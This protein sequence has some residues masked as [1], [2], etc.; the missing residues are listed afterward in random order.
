MIQGETH[1]RHR[2]FAKTLQRKGRLRRAVHPSKFRP[3]RSG[4]NNS[5]QVAPSRLPTYRAIPS[6]SRLSLSPKSTAP[7]RHSIPANSLRLKWEKRRA[8]GH[9]PSTEGGRRHHRPAVHRHRPAPRARRAAVR[10]SFVHPAHRWRFS[11][12]RPSS[13]PPCPSCRAIAR[14]LAPE[15]RQGQPGDARASV[16]T[17]GAILY[18]LLTNEVVGPA[19]AAPHAD[20]AWAAR[21]RWK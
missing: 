2:V 19:H 20:L 4:K 5:D 13:P 21:L 12:A 3:R 14:A 8:I 15:E 1:E 9:S 17:I 11:Q 6:C 10:S 7:M 16:F 18:E